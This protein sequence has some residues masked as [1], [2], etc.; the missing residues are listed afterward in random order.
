VDGSGDGPR[1][2]EFEGLTSSSGLA[3]WDSVPWNADVA[4]APTAVHVPKSLVHAV[5]VL[6]GDLCQALLSLQ[7]PTGHEAERL[8]KAL[9]WLDRLLFHKVGDRRNAKNRA[10]ERVVESRVS[11][12]RQGNWDALWHDSRPVVDAD[13]QPHPRE[14]TKTSLQRE[15]Q[16]VNEVLKDS[17]VT[18]GHSL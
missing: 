15:A 12:A 18:L 9:T 3:F 10:W 14:E 1:D 5:A 4:Y 6:R 11:Q 8:W 17:G 7:D 13:F 2:T 16:A